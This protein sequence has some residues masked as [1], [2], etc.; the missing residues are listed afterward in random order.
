MKKILDSIIGISIVLLIFLI[1]IL[2][3]FFTYYL[4]VVLLND[5]PKFEVFIFFI[6]LFISEEMLESIAKALLKL[7]RS[8]HLSLP[9]S[10]LVSFLA[11]IITLQIYKINFSTLTLVIVLAIDTAFHFL[12]LYVDKKEKESE[13]DNK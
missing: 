1:P 5:N 4:P 8:E 6:F 7:Q 11:I 13:L 9:F 12:K 3:L 10:L 2:G